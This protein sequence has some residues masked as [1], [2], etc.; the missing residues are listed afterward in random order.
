[1]TSPSRASTL[2][3]KDPTIPFHQA[4]T[5]LTQQDARQVQWQAELKRDDWV[6]VQAAMTRLFQLGKYPDLTNDLPILN[7]KLV[8]LSKSNVGPFLGE[9]YQDQLLKKCMIILRQAV[10]EEKDGIL[11][12]KLSQIWVQFYTSILPTLQAFFA[13]IQVKGLSFRALTLLSFRDVVLLKTAIRSA[14]DSAD[15]VSPE[16]KQMLLVLQSIHKTPSTEQYGQL[17]LLVSK[18]IHPYLAQ[19]QQPS[20][21]YSNNMAL[22]KRHRSLGGTKDTMIRQ[23]DHLE[24]V[25]S[26]GEL[27]A[28]GSTPDVLRGGEDK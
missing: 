16:I 22:V 8:K 9:F 5:S 2:S 11:L 7:E 19:K 20:S 27:F 23:L 10:K 13:P 1:M 18:V 26:S 14:L 15:T 24:S 25:T 4:L 21:T 6:Y 28:S 17:Q 3:L 12:E